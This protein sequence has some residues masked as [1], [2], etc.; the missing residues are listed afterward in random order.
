MTQETPTN[1]SAE[2]YLS[3]STDGGVTFTDLK[4]GNKFRHAPTGVPGLNSN[5][6]GDYIGVTSALIEGNP[7]NGNQRIWPYWMANNSGVYNAWT[8]KVELIPSN[9]CWGCEDF[10]SASFPPKYFNLEFSGTQYITRQN[11][12]AYGAGTGSA[13]I[14]FYDD[15]MG[16]GFIQSLV[17]H[18]EPTSAGYYL[19][20]DEAYAA[21]PTA[22]F[23]PDSLYVEASSN[24][25]SS[26]TILAG[27]S[28][29]NPSGGELNTA[30]PQ[31]SS[32]TPSSSQWAS[33]IYLL[34]A[35]TN[36]VRFRG[37]SGFGNNLYLDNICIQPLPAQPANLIA[38]TPQGFYIGTPN[39]YQGIPDTVSIYLHRT[40]FPNIIVDSATAL[41]N[42]IS[43]TTPILQRFLSGR[44]YIVV[45]HRNSIETWSRSGGELL[46]RGVGII[47][48]FPAYNR[49]YNNNQ[50]QVNAVSNLW[51]MFGGDID[52]NGF[53]DLND[54][55]L[56][57][58]NA[59][60]F[61]NG[62]VVTDVTGDNI[63][64]LNDILITYNNNTDFVM[65]QKPAGAEPT[66]V[67]YTEPDEKTLTFE[68]DAVRLKYESGK[69]E[70]ELM[71]NNIQQTVKPNWISD[72]PEGYQYRNN[73][74]P[75]NV[76]KNTEGRLRGTR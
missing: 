65:V 76:K 11:A 56:V 21:F 47:F 35:G 9:P 22:G 25:G 29:K 63:T 1:D 43:A 20:F 24:G 32:F 73:Y 48:D 34:P 62:Y 5:Y 14:A 6:A 64:D 36:T 26:Y 61:V 3:R 12:S 75:D 51:G 40:D 50:F 66:P 42:H 17:T 60:A 31:Y 57:Y 18:C 23:G 8:A 4:V 16:D 27:L 39:L 28:G 19:T 58:N 13:K 68:N 49:A 53:V 69:R 33:K 46:T 71:K 54:V 74:K 67:P 30:P 37:V 38:M 72:P 45:K 41:K 44:H 2:V 52:Q 10:S 55:N 15:F 59:N 70:R 7:V